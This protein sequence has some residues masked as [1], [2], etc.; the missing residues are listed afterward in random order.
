MS[1]GIPLRV[2]AMPVKTAR[3]LNQQIDRRQIAYEDIEIQIER[4]L[5]HLGRNQYPARTLLSR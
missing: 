2:T 3:T 5:D 4:L 1:S